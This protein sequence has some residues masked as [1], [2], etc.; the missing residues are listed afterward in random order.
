MKELHKI[1]NRLKKQEGVE[2]VLKNVKFKYKI[3][4]EN[5]DME[6]EGYT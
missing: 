6:T 4:Y 5:K 2:N 3:L 1:K